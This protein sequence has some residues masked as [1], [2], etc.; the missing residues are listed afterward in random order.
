MNIWRNVFIVL[1]AAAISVFGFG[2]TNWSLKWTAA[3]LALCVGFGLLLN[4]ST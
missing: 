4:R 1:E 2:V 3:G